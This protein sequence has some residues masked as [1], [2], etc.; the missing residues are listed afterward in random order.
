MNRTWFE[1]ELGQIVPAERVLVGPAELV[2]FQS[3][4]LTAFQAKPKAVA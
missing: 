4:G 1:K 2:S 3:D